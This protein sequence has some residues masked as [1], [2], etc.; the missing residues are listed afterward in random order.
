MRKTNWKRQHSKKGLFAC[1]LGVPLSWKQTHQHCCWW[2]GSRPHSIPHQAGVCCP[3][4][5]ARRTWSTWV[6]VQEKNET[7]RRKWGQFIFVFFWHSFWCLEPALPKANLELTATSQS[8]AHLFPLL[9]LSCLFSS[10]ENILLIIQDWVF[11]EITPSN[12]LKWR[13]PYFGLA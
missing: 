6:L 3:T 13:L 9:R 10:W 2:D 5:V 8:S 4:G 1:L 11:W 12:W 7:Q